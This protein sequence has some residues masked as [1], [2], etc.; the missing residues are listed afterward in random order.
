[1][2]VWVRA[3]HCWAFIFEDLHVLELLGGLGI[4][5]GDG[6][7]SVS[8]PLERECRRQM[9]GVQLCPLREDG[10]DLNGGHVRERDVMGWVEA[11]NVTFSSDGFGAKEMRCVAS[12]FM[13]R[14]VLR[15]RLLHGAEVVGEYERAGIRRVLLAICAHVARAQIAFWVVSWQRCRGGGFLGAPSTYV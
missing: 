14:A 12:L 6:A 5:V 2:R 15:L 1:V 4:A 13:A 3:A 8:V 11:Y 10:E 9:R 7:M